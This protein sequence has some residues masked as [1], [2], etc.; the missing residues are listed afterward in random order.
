M[1]SIIFIQQG[2][3]VSGLLRSFVLFQPAEYSDLDL[4]PKFHTISDNV[5]TYLACVGL[6]YA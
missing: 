4:Q 3:P 5:L 2:A 6:L 1:R